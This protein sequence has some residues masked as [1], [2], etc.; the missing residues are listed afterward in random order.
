M[1]QTIKMVRES[2]G[3]EADVH[4]AEVENFRKG[5]YVEARPEK[6]QAPKKAPPVRGRKKQSEG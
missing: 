1:A 5:G 4:P 3:K 6:A 2:D